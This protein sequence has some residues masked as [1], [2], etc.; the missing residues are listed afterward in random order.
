M[1]R[2]TAIT[3]TM[4]Q[5]VQQVANAVM[6]WACLHCR[7][8]PAPVL[9]PRCHAG[10][11][12]RITHESPRNGLGCDGSVEQGGPLLYGWPYDGAIRSVIRSIKYGGHR[13]ALQWL[14]QEA[15][16]LFNEA[17]DR[18]QPDLF[19][20]IP[21][22]RDR[23]LQRG[24]NLP[25]ACLAEHP[26]S[27]AITAPVLVRVKP[28]IA[29]AGLGRET[30]QVVTKDCM[31]VVGDAVRHRRVIIVDDIITTG[32]TM[33][34]AAQTCRAAGASWVGVVGLSRTLN[35]VID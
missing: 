21:A 33:S 6:P 13:A 25:S 4:W 29:L 22:S 26:A 24:F 1:K 14:G 28:T 8:H 20:P 18:Y 30:R 23:W 31:A 9:C 10:A 15:G 3:S 11:P 12:L 16:P 32:T 5:W 19:I 2:G 27:H 35:P 17:M 34:L 7:E